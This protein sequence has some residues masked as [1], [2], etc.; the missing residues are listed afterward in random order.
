[1]MGA[2]LDSQEAEHLSVSDL[3]I[4]FLFIFRIKDL[5]STISLTS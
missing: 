5:G 3:A 4:F 2:S 1:M